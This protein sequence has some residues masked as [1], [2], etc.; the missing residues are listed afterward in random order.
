MPPVLAANE[1]K[2]ISK[3]EINVRTFKGG[4]SIKGI[5]KEI[6]PQ[7]EALG[8]VYH[9]SIYIMTEGGKLVNLA[10]KGAAVS[11]WGDFTQKTR[12]RLADEWIE[13]YDA[14]ELQK[15]KIN[16]SIPKFKFNTSLTK[17]QCDQADET[18]DIIDNYINGYL[19][20]SAR[21]I[22]Q[23]GDEDAKETDPE[24]DDLPFN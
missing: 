16:Y 14:E 8:G 13:V 22:E 15:G 17:E 24:T 1:V 9:K 2:F 6:K 3:D 4:V 23:G 21:E 11:E 19:D 10:F 18:F 20:K 5:Y 12:N 7:I